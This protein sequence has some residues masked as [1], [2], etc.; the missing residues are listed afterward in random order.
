MGI[1]CA[2]HPFNYLKVNINT[3]NTDTNN[4]V[5]N[6]STLTD[7]LV[8]AYQFKQY[9]PK[10][11]PEN[12]AGLRFS[13]CQYREDK[14]AGTAAKDSACIEIPEM[15]EVEVT[16]NITV[17]MPHILGLLED[18]QDAIVKEH[19]KGSYSEVLASSIDIAAVIDRLDATGEGRLNKE[20]VFQWFD[21]D[22]KDMLMLAF[23]EK[24][25]ISD[26]PTTEEL[27]RL[28]TTLEVYKVKYGALAGANSHFMPEECDKLIKAITVASAE[29]SV[30]GTRFIR[31]LEKMKAPKEAAEMLGL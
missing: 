18:T 15:T 20:K 16:D 27:V 25:G 24:L 10:A 30:I 3:M 31:R 28:A 8:T 23:A 26:T 7:A 12:G 14:K 11:V 4:A 2:R 22:V 17:L 5:I 1:D 29:S 19:H 6:K 9:D 21:T 13:K